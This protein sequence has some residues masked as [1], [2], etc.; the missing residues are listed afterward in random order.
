MVLGIGAAT[1]VLPGPAAAQSSY[2]TSFPA[3]PWCSTSA[4]QQTLDAYNS[5][6]LTQ[7]TDPIYTNTGRTAP[8]VGGN[9]IYTYDQ[10]ASIGSNTSQYDAAEAQ[11]EEAAKIAGGY[12]PSFGVLGTIAVALTGFQLGWQIGGTFARWMHLSGTASGTAPS[13]DGFATGTAFAPGSYADGGTA[14]SP[15]SVPTG[16]VVRIVATKSVGGI[17]DAPFVCPTVGLQGNG[18][19]CSQTLVDYYLAVHNASMP[20]AHITQYGG[21]GNVREVRWF[22]VAEIDSGTGAVHVDSDQPDTGQPHTVTTTHTVPTPTTTTRGNTKEAT[23][24]AACVTWDCLT[25]GQKA[26]VTAVVIANNPSYQPSSDYFS[27]PNCVGLTQTACGAALDSAGQT[28][29]RTWTT[30]SVAA[31]DLT[32]PAA[33]VVTQ[34]TAAAASVAKTATVT[35]TVNPTPLPIVVLSPGPNETYSSYIARLTAAGYV[36]TASSSDLPEANLDPARGPHAVVRPD[37]AAGTRIA[38]DAPITVY[39]NPTDAPGSTPGTETTTNDGGPSTPGG[40]NCNGYLTASP[41]FTP[42]QGH[43]FNVFPFAIFGWISTGLGNWS[44]TGTAPVIDVPLPAW[45]GKHLVVDFAGIE[46]AMPVIRATITIGATLLLV[47]WLSTGLLG[48]RGGDE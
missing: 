34:G 32:K 21:S 7:Q 29:T 6:S 14:G 31:A 13:A 45:A 43:S 19:N 40:S 39:L 15:V 9:P 4:G 24:P 36:G 12:R 1:A 46:P 2:C 20:G 22:T 8:V 38:G 5:L 48:L 37:P 16:T 17:S 26:T 28:G 27:M 18:N 23:K 47:W 11:T 25:A 41:D 35:F 33:G 44:S 3:S 42:L 30:L 10:W